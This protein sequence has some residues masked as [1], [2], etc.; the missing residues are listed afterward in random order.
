MRGVRGDLFRLQLAAAFVVKRL[1]QRRIALKTFRRGDVLHPML[2]P[3]PIRG[4]EGANAR[5]GR[6]AGPGQHH[7]KRLF[8]LGRRHGVTVKM[9]ERKR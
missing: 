5:L 9:R 3:Q 4:A 7:H 2:F 1:H 8:Q 6:N